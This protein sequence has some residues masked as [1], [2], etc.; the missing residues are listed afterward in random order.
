M[1]HAAVDVPVINVLPETE[2]A[3]DGDVVAMPI[4]PFASTMN[5]VFV[6]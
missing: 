2:R 4:F 5:A 3:C 6:A 1:N